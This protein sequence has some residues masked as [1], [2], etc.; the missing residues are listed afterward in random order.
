MWVTPNDFS[1]T[2]SFFVPL[3]SVLNPLHAVPLFLAI[4]PAA[5]PDTT[6]CRW[7]DSRTTW[8]GG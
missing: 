4:M 5:A 3:F 8:G 6:R 7:S 2:L 1:F